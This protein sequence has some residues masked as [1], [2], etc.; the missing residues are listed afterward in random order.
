MRNRIFA[1]FVFFSGKSALLESVGCYL[2]YV[3]IFHCNKKNTTLNVYWD[4]ISHN[5]FWSFSKIPGRR[6]L[7]STITE[8][9]VCNWKQQHCLA[10]VNTFT[11][12]WNKYKITGICFLLENV[13]GYSTLNGVEMILS[14]V[15]LQVAVAES[16]MWCQIFASNVEVLG[17]MWSERS[18]D[19]RAPSCVFHTP[20][21]AHKPQ[22][23]YTSSDETN[24]SKKELLETGAETGD[25]FEKHVCRL[26]YQQSAPYTPT[27]A[28]FFWNMLNSFLMNQLLTLSNLKHIK[29]L[30]VFPVNDIL[31]CD[32]REG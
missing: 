27:S 7:Q 30:L 14:A 17:R 1:C 6:H 21:A 9:C 24:K 32:E 22:S 3:R 11:F 25:S 8:Q 23:S 2:S 5:E 16:R 10:F 28:L 31:H 20:A 4:Y 18:W 19:V 15:L 26:I 12:F 29:M 13:K